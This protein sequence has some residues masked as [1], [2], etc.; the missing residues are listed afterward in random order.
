[1]PTSVPD[2][3]FFTKSP[4]RNSPNTLPDLT[5]TPGQGIIEA[6]FDSAVHFP[7]NG[8]TH[9]SLSFQSTFQLSLTVL[10]RYRSRGDI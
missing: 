6:Y 10:V 8:F 5:V 7:M 1:M 4:A 3:N 9:F 2:P